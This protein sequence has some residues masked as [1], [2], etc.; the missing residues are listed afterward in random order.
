M[1]STYGDRLHKPTDVRQQLA[2]AINEA[3][4]RGGGIMIPA[5]AVG[6][7]QSLLYLL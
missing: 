2:G 4:E 6:R 5:F 7:S 3:V 1:E